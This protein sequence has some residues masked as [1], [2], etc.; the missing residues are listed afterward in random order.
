MDLTSNALRPAG[1]TS[2][3]AA[4]LPIF[5]GLVKYDEVASGQI[6][7]ALRFT[8]QHS[9]KAYI[10]PARHQASNNTDQNVPPMG[11]RFRLRADFDISG[12][13][14]ANQVIMKALK[15]YGMFVA[16]NGSSMYL[17]GVP[18]TRWNDDDLHQLNGMA[19]S[20]FEAVDESSLQLSPDSARANASAAR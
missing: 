18:D 12:Y 6:D 9:Q 3:D 19:G 8:V 13:S 2:A 10:W 1:L 20:D 14:P 4:G 15:R 5:Q 17:S 7:H 11:A 16:D